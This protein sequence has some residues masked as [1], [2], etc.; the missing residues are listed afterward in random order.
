M[1][2]FITHII[3]IVIG[4]VLL[5]PLGGVFGFLFALYLNHKAKTIEAAW[6]RGENPD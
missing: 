6:A 3:C 5:G 4:L 2:S 1:S